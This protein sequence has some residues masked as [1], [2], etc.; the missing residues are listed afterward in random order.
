MPDVRLTGIGMTSAR[1]R[2]RL[3]QR[4]REQGI[5]NLQ[6]LDRIRNEL[7]TR[8]FLPV[9]FDF[10]KPSTRDLTQTIRTL[11]HLSRFV[12]A[13]LTNAKSIPQELLAIVELLPN[14]PVQPLLLEGEPA[15]AMFEHFLSYPSVLDPVVYAN[16]GILIANLETAVIDPAERKANE[17]PRTWRP[18]RLGNPA[19][20]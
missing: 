16:E 17:P 3:V 13:D 6:V 12:I 4:L 15:Y 1:T 20:S 10:E 8:K 19:S 9:L 5:A 14:V 7:R 11:A 2:D 18:K